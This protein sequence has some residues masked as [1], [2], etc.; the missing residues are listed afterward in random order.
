MKKYNKPFTSD[1]IRIYLSF[2]LFI[3]FLLSLTACQSEK[4]EN[5][6]IATGEPSPLTS[7]PDPTAS[8]APT[9]A[10]ETISADVASIIDKN[11][12]TM[13]TRLHTPAGFIRIPSDEKE[14]AGFLRGLKLKKDGSEV[15]QYDGYP[16]AYQEGHAAVFE[17]DTGNKDLQQCA[18]SILRIYAEYYWSIEDY[19]KISF[20]LTNGFLMDYTKWRDG[21]RIV[22]NGNDVSWSKT[23][24]YDASYEVFRSYLETVFMYAGTLSLSEECESVS[25]DRMKPGDL[26]LQGGSPGHC[27]LVVDAAIDRMGNQCFLLAQG[28]MPAQDFHILKNPLHPEDPWYYASEMTYPL[29]TP[30]WSFDEGSLVRWRDFALNGAGASLDFSDDKPSSG[31]R[32]A[33]LPAMSDNVIPPVQK[34]SSVTLLAVGDNLIHIQVVDSGKQKDGTY[35][36]DH[37]YSNL[38]NDISSAD[39]AVVNQETILGGKAFAYSGY[40]EFNSPTEIGDALID[41]GFDVVL[42]ATNHTM[43]M[44]YKGVENDISYWK[45]HPDITVLGINETQ[46]E[47][48]T[49]PIVEKNGIKLAMLNYTFGLNGHKLPEDKPYLVNLLDKKKMSEDIKK[50]EAQADFTIV[51]PHWGTEYVYEP[52]REQKELTDFFYEQGVDLVIGT[53]PH[54]LEPVEWIETEKDHKMLVYYS[55]GNFMSYQKE[56]PRMLGGMA[57][58]TITKASDQTYISDAAIIPIVTHFENG[59]A[60]YNYAIYKLKDYNEALAGL[61]GVSDL[62]HNGPITYQETYDLAGQILGTWFKDE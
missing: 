17:L 6:P 12:S 33:A 9:K 21:Y 24:S 3:L 4:R 15:L 41:A 35:R 60:D 51:F 8:I 30:Q 58:I 56:A 44:G 2:L 62:A 19:D 37:L 32:P 20:H 48:D 34:A 55:L 26:F 52:T 39:I 38:K 14:L 28:F 57:E 18:D 7:V 45:K 36:Y 13:D 31:N 49:V 25:I 61:H 27:V 50:A 16:K 29:E 53:H 54:V 40:P 11:G 1:K 23:K 46:K 22:V 43:D 5:P 10:E 59:P 47:A 42:Q